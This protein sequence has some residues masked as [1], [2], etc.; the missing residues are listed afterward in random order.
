M[1]K[2]SFLSISALDYFFRSSSCIDIH[3]GSQKE[4]ALNLS[5][6]PNLIGVE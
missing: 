6:N 1:I 5:K 4:A 2:L 3:F